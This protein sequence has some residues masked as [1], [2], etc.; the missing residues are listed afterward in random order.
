M[1]SAGPLTGDFGDV[2]ASC[3]EAAG[4][5]AASSRNRAF[6]INRKRRMKGL[7]PIIAAAQALFNHDLV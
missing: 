4:N 2:A 3:A 7:Y 1:V 5:T 6:G